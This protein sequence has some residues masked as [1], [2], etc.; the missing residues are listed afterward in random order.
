MATSAAVTTVLLDKIGGGYVSAAALQIALTT[1]TGH[2]HLATGPGAGGVAAGTT[3]DMLLAYQIS[4][5]KEIDIA[6]VTIQA[7][8]HVLGK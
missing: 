3:V 2:V 5:T 4:T 8:V 6:D 7:A 1:P